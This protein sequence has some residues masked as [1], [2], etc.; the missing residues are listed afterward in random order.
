MVYIMV[1]KWLEVHIFFAENQSNNVPT[2]LRDV[3]K[4]CA[5]IFESEGKRKSFHYLFEPRIDGNPG[6]EILYRIEAKED[7]SLDELEGTVTDRM[8]EF[9][10]LVNGRRFTKDYHGEATDFGED[11][12][13]L[14]KQ[15]FE[16]GSEIAIGQLTADFR[17]GEKF[18]PG[19]LLHCFLNQNSVNEEK[20]HA[21]QL[22]G[23]TLITLK[24]NS[25]TD[26]VENRARKLLEEAI[27]TLRASQIRRI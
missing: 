9:L 11:G 22:V 6:F 24:S 14:T 27:T 12:W 25:V 17:K 2:I 3:V 18:L 23:R 19:K 7:T 15:L 16:I 26:E 21:T 1:E 20:F 4:H 5:D 13:E 8:K 10:Q